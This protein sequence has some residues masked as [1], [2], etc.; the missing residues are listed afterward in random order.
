M[1]M[2]LTGGG[3]GHIGGVVV[4]V[5]GVVFSVGGG[6]VVFLKT[7]A[8]CSRRVGERYEEWSR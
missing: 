2:V 5:I 6:G 7:V 4:A 8:T 3:V 1:L